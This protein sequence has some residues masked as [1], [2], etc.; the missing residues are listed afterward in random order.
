MVGMRPK[1]ISLLA[2]SALALA[3]CSATESTP[4]PQPIV[5]VTATPTASPEESTQAAPKLVVP[6]DN[7]SPEEKYLNGARKQSEVLKDMTDSKLLNLAH[8]SC[9]QMEEGSRLPEVVGSND[10]PEIQSANIVVY[11]M[12]GSQLCPD[13]LQPTRQN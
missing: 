6:E 1:L 5:T 7:L 4:E 8:E 10:V 3:G 13:S 11:G 12:A 2:V 9:E